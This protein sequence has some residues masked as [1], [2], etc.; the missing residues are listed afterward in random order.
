MLIII[1]CA[2]M[3]NDLY[4]ILFSFYFYHLCNAE[5]F[6]DGRCSAEFE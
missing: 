6:E 4:S 3:T 1:P 2:S 5:Q